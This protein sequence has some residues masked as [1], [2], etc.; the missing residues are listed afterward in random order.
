MI[1]NKPSCAL[2]GAWEERGVIGTRIEIKEPHITVLWRNSPVLETTFSTKKDGDKTVLVLSKTGLKFKGSATDY[3]R[4]TNLVFSDGKLEFE[5]DFPIT[6]PSVEILTK[7]ENS[8]YGNY[9]IVD[10]ELPRLEGE[11]RDGDGYITL[12]FE[13]NTM[14]LNG[15]KKRV[16]LLRSNGSYPPPG[17]LR[18]VDDDASVYEWEGMSNFEF[19]GEKITASLMVCDA[20]P[21]NLIF[22]KVK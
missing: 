6:G 16:H 2:D 10:G 14:T 13:G 20:K 19:D 1:D 18:L 22:T 12:V 8:R 5:K 4:V 9:E 21:I 11:W 15:D 17:T 7:T 3:G